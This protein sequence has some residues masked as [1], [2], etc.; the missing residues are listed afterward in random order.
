M[1]AILDQD[2]SGENIIEDQEVMAMQLAEVLSGEEDKP[3][4]LMVNISD[5]HKPF[6]IQNFATV[7]ELIL[8]YPQYLPRMKF[9]FRAFLD[10]Q[11]FE[12]N[13]LYIIHQSGERTMPCGN[14]SSAERG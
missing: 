11:S 4:C 9:R 14:H 12:L 8:T 2:S 5:P 3:F 1:D 10:D 13:S 6:T 7:S